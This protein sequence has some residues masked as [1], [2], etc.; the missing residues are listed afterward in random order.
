MMKKLTALLCAAA[1]CFTLAGCTISTPASVG[2][3]GDIE[4]SSGTYLLAQFQAYYTALNAAASQPSSADSSASSAADSTASADASAASAVSEASASS[5]DYTAM[6]VKKFLKQTITVADEDTGEQ[7]DWLVSDYIASET[8]KNLQYYAAVKTRFAEL[9]GALTDD[10]ISAADSDAE[11]IYSQNSA[12]Y[13][14][15]GFGLATIKDYEYVLTMA[16]DLLTLT[17]GPDGPEAVSDSDLTDYLENETLYGYTVTVPL[18]STSTYAT[19][20]DKA[21]QALQL[22]GTLADAYNAAA[23]AADVTADGMY[24]LFADTA[25]E[26]LPDVY[27]LY[28]NEYTDSTFSATADFVTD[29]TLSGYGDA[30]A[31]ALRACAVGE[32]V[33]VQPNDYMLILF[34]RM[35]PLA[36]S[37]LDDLRETALRDLKGD[38]LQDSLYSLGADTLDNELDTSA[39]HKLPAAKITVS[40]S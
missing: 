38:A 31:S 23:A 7:K 13:D 35:N 17:Y 11:S 25:A 24:S 19:D 10:E 2:K 14:A 9:G 3:I 15:N 22:C 4:I 1:L 5:V 21:A 20:T 30:A 29:S 27:A 12:L 28:S 18:Y 40:E 32:A 33:A 16:S 26:Y 34:L 8:T 36:V 37:T 6:S 39:I